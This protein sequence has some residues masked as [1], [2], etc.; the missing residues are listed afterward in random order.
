MFGR[1]SHPSSGAVRRQGKL[2]NVERSERSGGRAEAAVQTD[3]VGRRR[4]V[5]YRRVSL[6]VV[7]AGVVAAGMA[8]C[9][10]SVRSDRAAVGGGPEQATAVAV[11]HIRATAVAVATANPQLGISG[12][13]CDCESSGK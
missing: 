10:V 3:A 9:G 8:G 7:V 4:M 5:G 2:G 12:Q 6:I 11:A 1:L 13:P